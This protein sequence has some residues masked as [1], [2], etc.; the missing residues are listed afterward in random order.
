MKTNSNQSLCYCRYNR[1]TQHRRRRTKIRAHELDSSLWPQCLNALKPWEALHRVTTVMKHESIIKWSETRVSRVL[2]HSVHGHTGSKE[3]SDT[4]SVGWEEDE[5]TSL[6]S[7][8]KMAMS[9]RIS[10][11]DL[12]PDLREI[13]HPWSMNVCG[14]GKG[15]NDQS[16]S[17][18]LIL[19]VWLMKC[20]PVLRK[21]I[22]LNGTTVVKH[23]MNFYHTRCKNRWTHFTFSE[24]GRPTLMAHHV[25]SL[26]I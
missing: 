3:S 20:E 14:V 12:T 23:N 21:K 6:P 19:S 15:S 9:I 1:K 17:A 13:R 7:S 8:I 2:A 4:L 18:L 26:L 10:T 22:D 24:E 5:L 11:D 16:P 25:L